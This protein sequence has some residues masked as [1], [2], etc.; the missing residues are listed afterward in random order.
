[1]SGRSVA[2]GTS[3]CTNSSERQRWKPR[4][5]EKITGR[6]ERW[7]RTPGPAIRSPPRSAPRHGQRYT[8]RVRSAWRVWVVTGVLG[9]LAAGCGL[10]DDEGL[11]GGADGAAPDPDA[12]IMS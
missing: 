1:M 12:P 10:E 11:D 8:C 7:W 9:S 5:A 4:G 6:P 2:T 3:Q